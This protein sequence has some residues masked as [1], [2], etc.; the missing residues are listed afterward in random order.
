[1]QR[2]LQPKLLNINTVLMRFPI[3]E[4]QRKTDTTNLNIY[5][6]HSLTVE[7]D[8]YSEVIYGILLSGR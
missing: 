7:D 3:V 6:Y 8:S 1:M 5:E 4:L 2:L